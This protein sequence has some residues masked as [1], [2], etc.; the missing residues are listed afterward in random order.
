MPRPFA[1]FATSP[2]IAPSPMTPSF[3]PSISHPANLDFS[4]SA[5]AAMPVSPFFDSAHSMPPTMPREDMSRAAIA[6]SFT[7]F[8]FA[9]GVLN[10]TIPS[11]AQ[12]STGILFTPAPA[13]PI[14]LS[15][16]E[17]VMSCIFAERTRIAS[18][19]ATS[20]PTVYFAGSRQSV[21]TFAILLSSFIL[22]IDVASSGITAWDF[23]R[24]TA[25]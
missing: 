9:P 24:R 5:R 14:A 7:P 6:S 23:H 3:L 19:S 16:G 11:S 1:A 4:F 15:D 20:S 8:A 22:Y 2:P 13:L 17:K 18:G 25:S 10:T 12:R 21:P